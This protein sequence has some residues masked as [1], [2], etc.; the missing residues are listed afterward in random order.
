M[1]QRLHFTRWK[2]YERTQW[3]SANPLFSPS[4]VTQRAVTQLK[5]WSY[6][7]L[8]NITRIYPIK[9]R[10]TQSSFLFS[11]RL[12]TARNTRS[13]F[14]SHLSQVRS[15]WAN[16]TINK[17]TNHAWVLRNATKSPKWRLLKSHCN[18]SEYHL[19]LYS[20]RIKSS[21]K[22]KAITQIRWWTYE[23]THWHN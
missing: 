4:R 23:Q 8:Q 16:H 10:R 20:Y 9:Y 7:T 6:F 2:S 14:Y 18:Q 1:A 15:L 5:E 17:K 22:W 11:K 13:S 19:P 3:S 21:R 12:Q